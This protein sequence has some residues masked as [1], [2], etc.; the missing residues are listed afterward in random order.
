VVYDCAVSAKIAKLF[1]ERAEDA[2]IKNT[3]WAFH[4]FHTKEHDIIISVI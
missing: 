3:G 1:P 4:T 2:A